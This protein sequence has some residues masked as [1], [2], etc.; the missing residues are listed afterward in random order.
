MDDGLSVF[1][2]GEMLLAARR[3][4]EAQ[5]CFVEAQRRGFDF[6]ALAARLWSCAML[7]G[8]LEAAWRIS[9]E[10]LL[11]RRAEGLSCAGEP[12]HRQW[13]W[14]GSPLDGQDVLVRCHH[15]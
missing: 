10:V 1:D 14:D 4:D 15:G 8:D 13:I 9:D 7:R 3:V 11:R 5:A 6:H 12:L 2:R